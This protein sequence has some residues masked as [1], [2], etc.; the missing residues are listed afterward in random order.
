[1]GS[2]ASRI[3]QNPASKTDVS[4]GFLM[5]DTHVGEG[6][7]SLAPEQKTNFSL[8][9][10]GF[11]LTRVPARP[12]LRTGTR[13]QCCAADGGSCSCPRCQE[14]AN[15]ED[16]GGSGEEDT[17]QQAEAAAAPEQSAVSEAAPE[18][19]A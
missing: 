12:G 5:R 11:D 9:G 17:V 15:K 4:K 2:P 14:A 18:Q 3:L 19:S 7:Y 8:T 10:A 13:I 6:I 1:M 16:E